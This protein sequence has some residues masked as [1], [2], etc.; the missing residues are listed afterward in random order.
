MLCHR[1]A[2]RSW[3]L[4]AHRSFYADLLVAPARSRDNEPLVLT[5]GLRYGLRPFVGCCFLV[6]IGR[7]TPEE[8]SPSICPKPLPAVMGGAL[9]VLLD[10]AT[11]KPTGRQKCRRHASISGVASTCPPTRDAAGVA[12]SATIPLGWKS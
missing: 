6:F 1:G 3:L 7:G 12:H 5:R 2:S 11:Q 8:A 4:I 9:T 10:S